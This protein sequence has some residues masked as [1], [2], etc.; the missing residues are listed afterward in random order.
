VLWLH[1][2]ILTHKIGP[3]QHSQSAAGTPF[4][5]EEPVKWSAVVDSQRLRGS[6]NPVFVIPVRKHNEDRATSV[7]TPRA[8][9][10]QKRT[11]SSRRAVDGRPGDHI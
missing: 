7:E 6:I 11:R 8:I 10:S 5:S 1:E 4:K 2:Q 9:A 3:V